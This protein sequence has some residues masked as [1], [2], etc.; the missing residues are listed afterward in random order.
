MA[1]TSYCSLPIPIDSSGNI[2]VTGIF[3]TTG[4]GV[5]TNVNPTVANPGGSS[6]YSPDGFSFQVGS[7]PPVGFFTIDGIYPQRFIQPMR[8][9]FDR[10]YAQQQ[11]LNPA[12]QDP[13][14]NRTNYTFV[15]QMSQSQQYRYRVQITLFQRIYTYNLAAYLY[16]G[17]QRRAPVYYTFSSASELT[18][19]QDAWS[20]IRKLYYV[21]A[22]YSLGSIFFLPFPPF[23]N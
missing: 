21:N 15:Q 10:L 8:E 13:F 2:N 1:C 23:C 7:I 16:A 3:V 9:T 6:F 17:R 14:N 19:F 18:M 5:F 12:L 22:N 4:A 20:L 11:I